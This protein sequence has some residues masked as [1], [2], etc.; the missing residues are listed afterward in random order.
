M[1]NKKIILII[2]TIL[3]LCGCGLPKTELDKFKKYLKKENDFNCFNNICKNENIVG[4]L[5]Q[6]TYEFNF[7]LN[8]FTRETESKQFIKDNSKIVYNWSNN[9]AIYNSTTMGIEINTTYNYDTEEFI[10]NSEHDDKEYV[11]AECNMVSL[12]IKELKEIF[13]E[14]I[15]N[16]RTTYFNKKST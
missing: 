9:S 14:M 6:F 3:L 11:E 7:D 2:F 10:C 8:T 4:Q 13:D 5:M 12:T 1:N 15:I 16:S